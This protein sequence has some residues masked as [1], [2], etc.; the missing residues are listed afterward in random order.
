MNESKML[1]YDFEQPIVDLENKI[2]EIKALTGSDEYSKEIIELEKKLEELKKNI[3]SRLTRWQKVQIARHPDRPYSLDYFTNVFEDFTELHG[4]RKYHDDKAIIGGFAKFEGKSVMLVGHQKGHGTKD[5]LF[6]NF[7]MPNPEGYRKA[8]RLFKLA[9]KFNK[10]IIT[11]LD[12]PGA[13]PGI[14]A[15]ERGQAEAIASNLLLMTDLKTPIIV[16][17]IGEGASG[18]AIG[19]GV[20]DRILMLEYSWY[21]VISP[22]SCSSIL[23][24]S[25]D[26]K[27]QAAEALKLTA[28]DLKQFGIID[29]IVPEPIGGAH[30]N[31]EQIYSTL[32]N[33][34][35]EELK[36]LI[37]INPEKLAKLRKEKF[38]K[39]GVWEEK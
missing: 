7:G 26:Y 36:Q 38:Y 12:T 10:P 14:E 28:D 16:V 22:E 30:H 11:F 37:K 2:N 6:R 19:I 33:V 32:K 18:G 34:L 25:W 31:P 39:M 9:E 15:E 8:A 35:S 20:G 3:Y 29:R 5:N 23:W 1:I 24:R 27:E 17:I 21:S 13:Y 4:D